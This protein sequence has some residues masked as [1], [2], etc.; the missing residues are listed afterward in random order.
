[1]QE[2]P[3]RTVNPM[4]TESGLCVIQGGEIRKIL[5]RTTG[6]SRKQMLKDKKVKPFSEYMIWNMDQNPEM[7]H[8]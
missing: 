7:K 3:P 2:N 4:S 1:M 8:K 5:K 6:R